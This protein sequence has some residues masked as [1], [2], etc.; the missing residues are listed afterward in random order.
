MALPNIY[1]ALETHATAGARQQAVNALIEHF[2]Q[3]EQYHEM[4]EALKMSMRLELGLPAA[5][6]EF[7][8]K[9]DEDRE[10]QL[11]QGLLKACRRVGELF[12]K[13]GKIRE[14]WM[15][16]RPVGD[17]AIAAQSLATVEPNDENV[18][19]LLEVLVHEGVDIRRGYALALARMGTCNSITLFESA[20][21]PRP[22]ADQQVAADL[23]VRHVHGEL[24]ENLRRDIERREGLAPEGETL[25]QLL[26]SR[27]DL[28]RDGTYHLDTSHLASTVRFAR[29]L[30]EP[31]ALR[32][33]LDISLYGRQLHPQFQYPGEEPFLD[34]YPAS[35]AFFRA[36]LGEQIDAGVR[37]FTHKSDSVS[38][39]DFGSVAVEVLIDLLSRCGRNDEALTVYAKRL[40]PGTR[41]MGI[42][43]TLL[44]LSQRSGNY[45]K[46]CEICK[47]RDD[48]LSYAAGLLM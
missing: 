18:D 28:L 31:S 16:M 46:M 11:E 32:L 38:Q 20:L 45:Q 12:L 27:P 29:V 23:L 24:L 4:F 10:L 42:A 17:R 25:E 43:P 36:L 33:A 44:Q 6:A 41:T 37:Y 7:E 14:G 40:P 48:L 1:E 8:E 15:Y 5:Q 3:A 22:R 39:Q 35:I 19:D 9:L 30:D 21:A 47:T 26:S 13:Q 2:E 34:L